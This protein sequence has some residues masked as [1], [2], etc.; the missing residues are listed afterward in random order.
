MRLHESYPIILA[1]VLIAMTGQA[2]AALV[3][4]P[5]IIAAPSS[6]VNNAAEG[7]AENDHQQG[8]NEKQGVLLAAPLEV[9]DSVFI[10][11]GTFV[12]S[13]MIFLNTHP[14]INVSETSTWTFDGPILG[15]MSQ[16]LYGDLEFASTP[17]LGA[18]GTTYPDPLVPFP[19]RGLE[20]GGGRDS[21]GVAGNEITVTMNVGEPGDW[22][23]VV[24]AA[25]LIDIKPGSNPNSFN[26]NGN[27]VIPVA[28]LGSE[29]FDVTEIDV[30]TLS[31][32]GLDVRVKGNGEPQCSIK[33]TNGDGYD[34]LVCQFIDDPDNWIPGDG[35][36]TLTGQLNDGTVFHGTDSINV[37]P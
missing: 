28:V 31:F 14:R 23:R 5:D 8:F 17:I 2:K 9:D 30:S 22:I 21:Y 25:R 3:T 12:S 13:H 20:V 6:V 18:V 26:I 11:A 36:A 10:P 16:D 27:G 29:A 4:G 19:L 7:G 32:A 24:T 35:T 1:V 34:D 15:V 37:V 33:D